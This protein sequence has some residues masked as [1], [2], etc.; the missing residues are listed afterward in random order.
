[1]GSSSAVSPALLVGAST[2]EGPKNRLKPSMIDSESR[3]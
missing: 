3:L 2:E 1:M